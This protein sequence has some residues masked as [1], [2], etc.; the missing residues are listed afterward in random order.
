LGGS[1]RTWWLRSPYV[2]NA[3]NPRYVYTSG[4]VDNY[5]AYYA[6]GLAPACVII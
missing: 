3:C 5:S 6:R 4:N 1:A 2:G